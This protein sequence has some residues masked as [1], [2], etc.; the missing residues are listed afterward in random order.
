MKKRAQIQKS[1]MKPSKVTKIFITHSHGDH[2]F[3]L[4]GMLCLLG[5]SND[6][7]QGKVVEIFGPRVSVEELFRPAQGGTNTENS[8]IA[9]IRSSKNNGTY[10]S[11]QRPEK[12]IPSF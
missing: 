1:T 2:C 12:S 4:P 7:E 5:Q 3:G 9:Q 10:L 6:R 11:R 8:E